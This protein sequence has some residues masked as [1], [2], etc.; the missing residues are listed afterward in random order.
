MTRDQALAAVT[1]AR[2]ARD[3]AFQTDPLS[4]ETADAYMVLGSAYRRLANLTVDEVARVAMD[5]AADAL[6]LLAASIRMTGG[7]S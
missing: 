2:E 5:E 6:A 1:A 7:G 3:A 4:T